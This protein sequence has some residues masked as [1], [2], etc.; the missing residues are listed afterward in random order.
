MIPKYCN[1]YSYCEKL[2]AGECK[3]NTIGLKGKSG[4]YCQE[5]EANPL[6][7]SRDLSTIHSLNT[8]NV[9][10]SGKGGEFVIPRPIETN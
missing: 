8:F 3:D 10:R 6:Y 2:A 9:H 7:F 4:F 1:L 5:F